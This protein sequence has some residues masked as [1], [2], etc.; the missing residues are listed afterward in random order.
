M[1]VGLGDRGAERADGRGR[2]ADPV[3]R[4]GIGGVRGGVDR[5][6][7]GHEGLGQ[8]AGERRRPGSNPGGDQLEVLDIEAAVVVDVGRF[9]DE[10]AAL[11]RLAGE[12]PG[13]RRDIEV[14]RADEPVAA[15]VGARDRVGRAGP[16]GRGSRGRVGSGAGAHLDA[17][18]PG[19]RDRHELAAGIDEAHRAEGDRE[20]AGHRRHQGQLGQG[21]RTRRSGVGLRALR[22]TAAEQAARVQPEGDA[23]R[24][25]DRA[26]GLDVAAESG[27]GDRT[28]G[29]AIEL[30]GRRVEAKHALIARQVLHADRLE[31]DR[32][33]LADRDLLRGADHQPGTGAGRCD[34][35]QWH[36]VRV[37]R[38][39]RLDRRPTGRRRLGCR[40]RPWPSVA[41]GP[42][43]WPRPS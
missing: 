33:R 21:D 15:D 11:A 34:G 14:G 41:E 30:G 17:D 24:D 2:R 29:Q 32:D 19:Q 36:L 16:K 9:V 25:D 38:R 6:V 18:R 42:R 12:A 28:L 1:E 23:R 39:S 4:L 13:D 10:A 26:E 8:V 7:Q 37:R 43:G 40:R 3:A 5:E 20:P 31:R 35:D 22:P 27:Q